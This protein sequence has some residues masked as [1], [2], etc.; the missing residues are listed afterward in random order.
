MTVFAGVGDS[1][2]H[3]C[4]AGPADESI[5]VPQA[6][7]LGEL[8]LHRPPAVLD[9]LDGV[10]HHDDC[11]EASDDEIIVAGDEGEVLDGDEES[12]DDGRPDDCGCG[13]WNAGLELPCWPCYRDGFEEPASAE[14]EV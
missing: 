9:T 6:L 2:E 1:D 4:P 14:E 7:E 12:D 3:V 11:P 8:L 5:D 13:D 10:D